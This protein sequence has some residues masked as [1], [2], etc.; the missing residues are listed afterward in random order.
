MLKDYTE[1]GKKS[2]HNQQN[3]VALKDSGLDYISSL[4]IVTNTLS[5]PIEIVFRLPLTGK[6]SPLTQNSLHFSTSI[7]Y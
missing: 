5:F 3:K 7:F 2:P 1:G 4:E 6:L